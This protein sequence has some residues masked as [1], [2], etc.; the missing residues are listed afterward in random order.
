MSITIRESK[1]VNKSVGIRK[2]SHLT[3]I[4]TFKKC[5]CFNNFLYG[6][7]SRVLH[8]LTILG[9]TRFAQTQPFPFHPDTFY[10]QSNFIIK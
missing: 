4:L 9:G 8:G 5:F 1:K 7:S 2:I 10:D 3:V 6:L